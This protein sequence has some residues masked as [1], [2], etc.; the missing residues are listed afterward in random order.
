M[1]DQI[2]PQVETFVS[3]CIGSIAELELVLLVAGDPSKAWT[4]ESIA[5]QLYVTPASV[6]AVLVR[7]TAKGLLSHGADG[8]R[9][10]PRTPD[11]VETV[12]TLKELYAAR[13]LKVVE[14][15]YAGPTEKYQ[16]FADAF[17]LRKNQ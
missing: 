6:D 14:M 16:R 12:K 7:M 11:L 8:Y 3:D 15:I 10:A 2:P 9:F 17:R 5:A 4:V 13:R 1:S